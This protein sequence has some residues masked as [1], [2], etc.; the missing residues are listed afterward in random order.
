MSKAV[1]KNAKWYLLEEPESLSLGEFTPRRSRALRQRACHMCHD[2]IIAGEEHLS[3]WM[4]TDKFYPMR[5][6]FCCHCALYE[7]QKCKRDHIKAARFLFDQEKAVHKYI[8]TKGLDLKRE[9][10]RSL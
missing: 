5:L 3:V 9:I 6:N 10:H 4:K 2:P 8:K 1:R 7:L